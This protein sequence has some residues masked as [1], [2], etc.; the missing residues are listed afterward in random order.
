[1]Q[2]QTLAER[3]YNFSAVAA[4]LST[5]V[6]EIAQS[7]LLSLNGTGMSVM[8]I[9]HR[10]KQFEAIIES[11]RNGIHELLSVPKNYEVLFLQGGA[12]LQFSMIP[13]NFLTK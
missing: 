10:S 1:M 11:A 8:E 2:A 6:L 4:V 13:L 5:E 9:S 12:S 7:E 3:I